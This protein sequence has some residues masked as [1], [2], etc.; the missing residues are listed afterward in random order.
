MQ[1]RIAPV[2]IPV[3]EEDAI[4]LI[5][6]PRIRSAEYDSHVIRCRIVNPEC[7]NVAG[8][9]RGLPICIG[10]SLDRSVNLH[11]TCPVLNGEVFCLKLVEVL[12]RTLWSAWAV[13]ELPK[14]S[15][16]RSIDVTPVG[17]TEAERSPWM[18]RE[19]L[20]GQQTSEPRVFP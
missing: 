18:W 13:D 9:D 7:V 17:L 4:Q 12:G 15:G 8:F 10:Q 5:I 1:Q 3:L 2:S 19:K 6:H 20:G 11:R 14:I 16:D